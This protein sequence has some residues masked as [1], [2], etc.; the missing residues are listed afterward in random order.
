MISLDGNNLVLVCLRLVRLE[1]SYVQ[2]L[3]Q[4]GKTCKHRLSP[5]Q[6]W[7]VENSLSLCEDF[8]KVFE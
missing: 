5:C 2:L 7:F 8:W 6:H 3:L 4:T 1:F